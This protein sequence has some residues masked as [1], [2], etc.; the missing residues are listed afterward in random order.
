MFKGRDLVCRKITLSD[1]VKNGWSQK[2]EIELFFEVVEKKRFQKN[3]LLKPK[4]FYRKS[5]D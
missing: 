5:L 3:A 4:L 2:K 1:K